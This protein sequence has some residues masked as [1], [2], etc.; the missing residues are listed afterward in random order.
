MKKV[1]LSIA[2]LAIAI[3]GFCSEPPTKKDL[4]KEIQFTTE[5]IIEWIRED[6]YNGRMMTK[7][8]ADIYVKNLLNIL[9]KVE[10]LGFEEKH[11]INN[12]QTVSNE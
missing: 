9:S 7:E 6:Q 2:A 5:D 11:E 3:S 4:I 1:T 12:N 10:D 8:L